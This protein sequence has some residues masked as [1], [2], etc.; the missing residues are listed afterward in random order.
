[1]DLLGDLNIVAIAATPKVQPIKRKK[2]NKYERR[3]QKSQN[4]KRGQTLRKGKT[5]IL[6]PKEDPHEKNNSNQE[7]TYVF[8]WIEF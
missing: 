5:H 1:M 4:A 7:D 3:R 2:A 8:A 6:T